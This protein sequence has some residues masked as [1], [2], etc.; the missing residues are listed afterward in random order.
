MPTET[1]TDPRNNFVPR[2]LP[3]LLA[4]A[5][6]ALYWLTLN[7]SVSLFNW[8]AVSKI[9]GWTWRPEV[10][11]PLTFLATYPFRWLPAAAVPS[12]LDIFSALCASLTLCL[13]ART[14]ALLPHDRTEAQR[15]RESSDFSILTTRSAWL[16]PLLAVLICGLQLTFWER[17]TNFTGEMFDLLLFAFVVLSLAEYRLDE[18]EWRLFLAAFVFAA[19]MTNDWGMVAFFPL[20]LVAIVWLRGLGIFNLRFLSRMALCGLAGMLFYLLLP[21]LTVISGGTPFT[22]WEL[23][24]LNLSPQYGV[25]K[26]FMGTLAHP[27]SNME[28]LSLLLAYFMPVFLMAIRWKPSFGDRSKIGSSLA[29]FIFHLIHGVFLLVCLWLVFDPPFSPRQRGFGLT[30]YYLIAM[31]AG[32]YSGYFL[33]IFGKQIA[34]AR[35]RPRREPASVQW[36]N[37]VVVAGIWLLGGATVAGLIYRNTPQIRATNDGTLQRYGSFVASE[38]PRAGGYLM[39]DDPQRLTL[40]QS[41]LARDGRVRD[42]VPLETQSLVVPAYHRFLHRNFPL[43]WPELVSPTQTNTLNPVGLIVVVTKLSQTNDFYYLHPSFGY[44]FEQFYLEP[45]GLAYKMKVMPEDTQLPPP[46][47]KNLIA[48][49]EN[50]WSQTGAGELAAIQSTATP[51][52]SYKPQTLGARLLKNLHAPREQNLNAVAAG[53]YYSRDLD[54]W[55]VKL[56]CAG[57]LEKAAACFENAQKFNPDNQVA[58]INLDFNKKLRAGEKMAVDLSKTTADQFGKF[59]TLND[60]LNADGPFDEPSFCFANGLILAADNGFFRQALADFTRVRSFDPDYLPA[61]MWVGRIYVMSHLPRPALDELREPLADPNKFSLNETNQTELNLIAAAAYFQETNLVRGAELLEKEISWH[62]DNSTLLAVSA[63]A[64][65]LH[66]MF[67]NALKVVDR[68][69]RLAP[70]DPDPLFSRG[71]ICIQLKD[72]DGAIA[73]LN[74]VLAI[75]P[76]NNDA[77]YN[78]AIAN[79]NAGRLDAARADYSRL[80]KLFTNSFQV[81]YGL[82]DIA[83]Q[84]HDTNEAV[85]NYQIYRATVGDTNSAEAKTVLERLRELKK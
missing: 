16:P 27:Q 22:F 76:T 30:S 50:F 51:P 59:S 44:Y 11:N 6:L 61:R 60:V 8:S 48:E 72:Y 57:E 73:N 65:L 34:N 24:K 81:A 2:F 45:H 49:N 75:Q 77:L 25:V 5:M 12:A 64:F 78:R 42:F 19:G 47:D 69:L 55:G 1:Q 13:L 74:R 26:I 58:Q 62:P 53:A 68:R 23:L 39:S 4:V 56:Q 14:V 46:P 37:R 85:R 10:L 41:A 66:G 7:Y 15:V 32:Y 33:L 54:L 52:N 83:W 28:L 84:Q 9:S 36:Q 20:F 71:Y 40:V 82:G 70:D 67:S 3:W 17:A 29:S 79:L 63:Q 18:R 31:C 80:Q 43:K 38:L 35:R 21:V